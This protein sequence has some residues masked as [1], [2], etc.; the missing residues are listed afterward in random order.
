MVQMIPSTYSMIRSQYGN[1]GLMPGYVEGMRN[2]V[3]A[4]E[5]MLLYMQMTWNDLAS[6]ATVAGAMASGIATEKKLMAG[7]YNS[8]PPKL[9]RY[10]SRAG[11]HWT[12]LITREH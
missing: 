3:N 6:N 11:R 12:N 8:N 5:A 4:T 2:H 9:S 10:I 1:V 7:A